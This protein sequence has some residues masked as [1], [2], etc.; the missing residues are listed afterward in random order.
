M[1][2]YV[3]DIQMMGCVPWIEFRQFKFTNTNKF[4]LEWIKCIFLDY[5]IQKLGLHTSQS[6]FLDWKWKKATSFTR[7]K[8]TT[9]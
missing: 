4:I 9:L 7:Y 8:K 1:D 3:I 5:L 2:N 6:W